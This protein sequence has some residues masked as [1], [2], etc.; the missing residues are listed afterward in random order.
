MLAT[1]RFRIQQGQ[2]RHF[3]ALNSRRTW[4]DGPLVAGQILRAWSITS[5]AIGG[6]RRRTVFE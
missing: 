1:L 5:F 3:E 2:E 4:S 6:P